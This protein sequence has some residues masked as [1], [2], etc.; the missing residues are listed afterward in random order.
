[1]FWFEHLDSDGCGNEFKLISGNFNEII[2]YIV[3]IRVY[4]DACNY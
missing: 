2:F 4:S 1:M 3:N